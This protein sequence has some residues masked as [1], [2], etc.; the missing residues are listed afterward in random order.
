MLKTDSE[1]IDE[2][3]DGLTR[4]SDSVAIP[5]SEKHEALFSSP[6][7]LYSAEGRYVPEVVELKREVR[8]QAAEAGFY[9]MCVPTEL[10]GGNQ[11]PL[12]HFLAWERLFQRYGPQ[13]M[14]VFEGLSHW[15]RGPSH[16][17]LEASDAVRQI[18]L[19]ELM[20]G[21]KTICF[22]LS[23]PDAGSDPW[24][25]RTQA[26]K[27]DAGWTL[28]GTKQWSTNGPTA[29]YA[30]VFAVT[31][32]EQVKQRRAGVTAFLVPAD[33]PGFQVDSVLSLFGSP[34]G[35][36]AII[37]LENVPVS[38][39]HVVGQIGEGFALAMSGISLGRMYNAG[40]AVG[41]SRWAV[42]EATRYAQERVTFGEK[43]SEYQSVQNLLANG[44]INTYASRMMALDCARRLE[45]GLP[46]RKELA[47]VKAFTTEASFDTI[48][49]CMQ[50][51]GGMG[52]T[53][54]L[55]LYEAWHMARI[56]RVADGSAEIMR[57]TIARQLLRGDVAF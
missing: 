48:D 12:L 31:D 39:E 7:D 35:D 42:E 33:A 41:L 20:N 25:M 27:T 55:G 3:L 2:L 1:G 6:R 23:E 32:R 9:S 40:R 28:N 43:I 57:R 51:F 24:N 4:F 26:T 46:V 14:L 56:S 50:V 49:K 10:G 34:G 38:D 36:E 22:S 19:P 47:M 37:S 17:F 30:L 29:D 44:A 5:L 8:R 53:N 54:E 21:N 13:H 15:A 45:E 11:G 52:F 16:L 18:V